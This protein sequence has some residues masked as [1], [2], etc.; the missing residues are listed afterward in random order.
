[1]GKL[2][3]RHKEFIV[4][5]DD[6]RPGW[7][8]IINT[9][10]KYENHGHVKFLGTCKKLLRLMDKGTVPDSPYLRD[11]ALRVS[12][13]EKY[14]AKVLHKIEKD[15]NKQKYFNSQKGVVK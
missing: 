4:I 14:K 6:Y 5:E 15:K 8:I 12:L 3:H 11:T 13:D 10:G 7:H 1:M 2:V 9:L